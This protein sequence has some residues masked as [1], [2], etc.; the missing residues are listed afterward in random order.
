MA[1]TFETVRGKM[2]GED[3]VPVERPK[4]EVPEIIHCPNC[5]EEGLRR[6]RKSSCEW[7]CLYCG[8][9]EVR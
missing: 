1:E 9:K 6:K 4:L 5:D 8:F 3:P 7:V 2:G